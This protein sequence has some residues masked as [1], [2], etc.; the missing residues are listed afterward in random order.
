MSSSMDSDAEIRRRVEQRL[1]KRKEFLIHLMVFAAINLGVWG[2]WWLFTQGIPWP[3]LLSLPWGAGLAAH[4]IDTYDQTSGARA[5]T[6]ERS[7]REEMQQIFGDA[8]SEEANEE[9]YQRTRRRVEKRFDKH[10]EF[11]MHISVYIPINILVWLIWL[12]AGSAYG[13]PWPSLVSL[14]WGIGLIAHAVGAYMGADTAREKTIQREIA[15][16]RDRTYG[17]EKAKRKRERLALSDDGELIEIEDEWDG[18]QKRK[19]EE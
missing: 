10:R 9:D 15:R 3:L 4:F 16:E 13:F 19:F 6:R 5:A 1:N 14:G 7:V 2:I 18:K 17:V 11:L 12:V 8:W